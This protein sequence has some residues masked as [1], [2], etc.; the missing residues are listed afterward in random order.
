LFPL[1]FKLVVVVVT[2]ADEAELE[3]TEPDGSNEVFTGDFVLSNKPMITI[4]IIDQ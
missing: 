4:I 3:G 1:I 2:L